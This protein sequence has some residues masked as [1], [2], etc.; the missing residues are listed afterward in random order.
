MILH[1]HVSS[2]KMHLVVLDVLFVFSIVD[3]LGTVQRETFEG[4]NFRKFR[5][6]VAIRES[7]F[8][9][10]WGVAFFGT[11][12]TSNP[13]KFF[14]ENRIFHQ[15][16]IVFSLKVS[17]YTVDNYTSMKFLPTSKVQ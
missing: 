9:E 2:K 8:R 13:Q 17:R 4:E 11:A 14:C 7:F 12:K 6:F 3:A 1:V 5:G 16:A 10:I 15:F